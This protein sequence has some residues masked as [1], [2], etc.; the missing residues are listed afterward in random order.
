MQTYY[1][2][3]TIKNITIALMDM[4][5]QMVVKKYDINGNVVKEIQVPLQ[6][7]PI[8]KIQHDRLENHY[9][10]VNNVEHGQRF[11][12]TIPRMSIT[13]ESPV[14]NADRAYGV[15]E[16]RYWLGQQLEIADID[17]VFKDYQPTPYDLSYT[18]HI[19][20]DS[21][22]YLSQILE[23]ILPY[24]NPTLMLRVKE[25]S[26]LNIERDL[27]VT[28]IGIN[29][30]FIDD[31]NN[32]D[33]KYSNASISFKVDAFMYRPWDYGKIIKVINSKYYVDTDSI[34][35]TSA[36]N[37]YYSTSGVQLTSAGEEYPTSSVPDTYNTSGDYLDDVKEFHW[38]KGVLSA[39]D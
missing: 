37:V 33:T 28:I 15:N 38:Y 2:P 32:E 19:K 8:D 22:D 35:N 12:L 27:P 26:F 3:K 18:L 1:Y 16:Y 17:T 5:N 11:Y 24:F 6:F 4:F 13:M 21:L 29:T 14:Y 7:G 23:N 30:E 20:T 25:F 31:M 39:S 36:L 9:F 10:D 34:T